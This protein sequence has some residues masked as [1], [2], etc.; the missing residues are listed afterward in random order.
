MCFRAF[1]SCLVGFPAYPFEGS[2]VQ[3]TDSMVRHPL[4]SVTT[5]QGLLVRSGLSNVSLA[6]I[7]P[8][9]PCE[10]NGETRI[11][12]GTSKGPLVQKSLSL[13]ATRYSALFR[14]MN[15]NSLLQKNSADELVASKPNSSDDQSSPNLCF[16]LPFF[17]SC[18]SLDWAL[19][20][21]CILYTS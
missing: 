10:N 18:L 15:L 20:N 16:F 14:A 21:F 17:D 5:T 2:K 12:V 1:C 7:T 13:E 4:L 19:D 8:S 3:E 11:Q 9:S 6:A